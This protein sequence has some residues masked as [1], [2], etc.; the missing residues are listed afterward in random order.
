MSSIRRIIKQMDYKKLFENLPQPYIIIRANGPDYTFVDVS[1]SH[2]ALTGMQRV[3]IIDR[4]FFDVFP[5]T[6][7]QFL[8][9]GVSEMDQV[10]E[11]LIKTKKPI[12]LERFRYDIAGKDG[13]FVE[14]YWEPIHY[15]ILD[16]HGDVAY[17]L[18]LASD[19][20]DSQGIVQRLRETEKVLDLALQSGSLAV[21]NWDVKKDVVT[22]SANLALFF[23]VSSK[24]VE[25]GIP[26][27][28]FT[29]AMHAD[30]RERVLA[31]IQDSL[32]RDVPFESEYRTVSRDG[33][34]RWINARGRPEY[35][36]KKEVVSFP[37]MIID[38]TSRKQAEFNATFLA[39]SSKLLSSSLDYETT[40]NTIALH[41][42]PDIADWCTVSIVNKSGVLEQ[43][44]I[45]HK[46][47]K[48]REWAKQYGASRPVTV[49]D[50][51]DASARVIRTGT[52][53]F[54]PYLSDEV[55]RQLDQTEE[56]AKL[57]RK[58]KLRSII[59]VPLREHHKNIGVVTFILTGEKRRYTDEDFQ[60]AQE[61]ADRMSLA[62]SNS[63]LYETSVRELDHRKKLQRKLKEVNRDLE[64]RVQRRTEQLYDLNINLER[65]NGEL[66][67]FAYV[68]SHDLQEPLRKIQAFGDIIHDEY[69]DV[70]GDGKDYL[71]RMQAA[72]ERMSRLIEDLLS[73]SRVTTQAKEFTEVDLNEVLQD[74]IE[75]VGERIR[76]TNGRVD[77]GV[78]PTI[79]GDETQLRQLLQ[80]LIANALKF[81]KPDEPPIVTVSS[82]IHDTM[83]VLQ[84]TDNGI[85]FDQKYT[86][87]IFAVFQRLHGKAEYEGTGI[88]LAVCRKIAERHGG[89]ITAT[90]QLGKGSTFM[91]EL[92]LMNKPQSGLEATL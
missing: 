66:E 1:E 46:D 39:T 28:V 48:Q 82:E 11:K 58:L 84:V 80:N 42:I 23:G 20:T 61:L 59:M 86:D 3:E 49:D 2:L 10:F 74:V 64:A 44:A 88:G 22:G 16:D 9:T 91:V 4:N 89:S 37:G 31:Q 75:D 30:D 45:A 34:L 50:K 47:P 52:P 73:F 36:K 71:E 72:A 79:Y 29:T 68:A 17:I 26:I 41:T 12:A 24:Q 77:S 33:T 60:L 18:Q 70:L 43:V 32:Q 78:L 7:E 62:I 19:V 5:D 13:V 15:P 87:R 8:T 83:V 69:G 21:W 92:S 35:G 67:N 65:S 85:G 6:S 25:A 90:S 51:A 27:E 76:R 63:R 40:I 38:I 54:Y 56:Q 57:V 55:L 14:K 53:E 81:H